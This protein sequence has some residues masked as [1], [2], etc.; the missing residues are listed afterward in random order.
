[1][2]TKFVI[3]AF[4]GDN[5]GG[6]LSDRQDEKRY[7]ALETAVKRGLDELLPLQYKKSAVVSAPL[8]EGHIYPSVK[9]LVSLRG[10]PR[11]DAV[12]YARE[13]LRKGDVTLT[14]REIRLLTPMFGY[15]WDGTFDVSFRVGY[16]K[17]AAPYVKKALSSKKKITGKVWTCQ[18]CEDLAV[19]D[20]PEK[21]KSAYIREDD[22]TYSPLLGYF[23]SS[24]LDDPE[25]A[26]ELEI[27]KE[28]TP[29]GDER[30]MY[31]PSYLQ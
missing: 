17:N 15:A 21:M 1:M 4:L 3:E 18:H 23:C 2:S 28:K 9:L 30:Y 16:L 7:N 22:G 6:R 25:T 20:R 8:A 13:A 24:C 19:G 5:G 26:A 27:T 10:T 14:L 11:G 31:H 12:K 29:E